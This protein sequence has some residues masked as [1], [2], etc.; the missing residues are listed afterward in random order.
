M[1]YRQHRALPL[2]S[3]ASVITWAGLIVKGREMTAVSIAAPGRRVNCDIAMLNDRVE[4]L[5]DQV[6]DLGMRVARIEGLLEGLR[7]SIRDRAA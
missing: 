2:A 1:N 4:A 6:N 3:L 5:R 7:D